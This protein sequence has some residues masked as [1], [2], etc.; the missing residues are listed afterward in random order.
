MARK[1]AHIVL[2]DDY[3]DTQSARQRE[4]EAHARVSVF[5]PSEIG[6][7]DILSADLILVDYQIDNWKD[8]EEIKS[9]SLR[10]RDGLAL[11]AVLRAHLEDNGK[12][13]PVAFAIYSAHLAR[14]SGA[15]REWSISRANNLEW[16]FSKNQ[17][18][19]DTPLVKQ[20][21]SL[22]DSIL[23]LPA[24]WPD[25]DPKRVW[26][27]AKRLLALPVKTKWAERATET[28]EECHPPMYRLSHSSH[29]LAFLRWFL[30]RILPYPC[31][32]SD[33]NYLAARLR[34]SLPSLQ[35]ALSKSQKFG[36]AITPF[37]YKGILHDFLGMRW[38]RSGIESFLWDLTDG[39]STD[40]SRIQ[41]KVTELTG[42]ELEPSKFG[43]PIVCLDEELRAEKLCDVGQ[44]VRIQPEDWPPYADQAWTTIELASDVP[45]LRALVVAQDKSR[46]KEVGA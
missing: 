40:S 1:Q 26:E 3:P 22:A 24:D 20:M 4:L 36:K 23:K 14:L 17:G 43:H 39:N 6:I 25:E 11:A 32:L 10:P 42:F 21:T 38:W 34:V 28:V 8:R 12:A 16:A 27:V 7:R 45:S 35:E 30:Q 41:S 44:A 2:I 9:I 5:H 19:N 33:I 29:G 31:F 15:P 13:S 37:L 18:R 46:L